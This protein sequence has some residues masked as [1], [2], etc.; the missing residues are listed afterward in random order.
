M[1]KSYLK[2]TSEGLYD[3]L[4]DSDVFEFTDTPRLFNVTK[5]F[6]CRPD[7]ISLIFYGTD[8]HWWAILRANNIKF[9]F[10]ASLT[11]RRS[12]DSQFDDNI[13]S[14]LYVNAK[15]LIPSLSDIQRHLNKLA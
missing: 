2:M 1:D 13:Y 4:S 10:R 12:K 5:D 14:G 6:V 11:L 8:E 7:K 3:L 9:G 15:I